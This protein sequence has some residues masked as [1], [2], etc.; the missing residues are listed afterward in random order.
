MYI[1]I[2]IHIYIIYT[3]FSILIWSIE[4]LQNPHLPP[5]RGEGNHTHY[6]IHRT[7]IVLPKNYIAATPKLQTYFYV[8]YIYI[9]IYD[10]IYHV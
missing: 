8:L 2:Y 7:D 5:Q 6:L 4:N 1:Y 3:L 10:Y 9:Y